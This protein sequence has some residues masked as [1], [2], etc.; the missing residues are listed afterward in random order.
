M[1]VLSHRSW[2]MPSSGASGDD[3]GGRSRVEP[4]CTRMTAKRDI[5]QSGVEPVENLPA[6][7]EE[8]VV[9]ARHQSR[10]AT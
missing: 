4:S 3:A 9:H 10:T 1:E 5:S 6:C 2:E 8:S 7:E